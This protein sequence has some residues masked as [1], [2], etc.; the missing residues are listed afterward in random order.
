MF[1]SFRSQTFVNC[2]SLDSLRCVVY[3]YNRL[4]VICAMSKH[5]ESD[6]WWHVGCIYGYLWCWPF[7]LTLVLI[8]GSGDVIACWPMRVWQLLEFYAARSVVGKTST[9]AVACFIVFY[10]IYLPFLIPIESVIR[11]GR[12]KVRLVLLICVSFASVLLM[13]NQYYVIINLKAWFIIQ[14]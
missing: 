5:L 9:Y 13:F 14:L 10:I 3:F 12:R 4:K 7:R 1:L 2:T 8:G 6:K 11:G